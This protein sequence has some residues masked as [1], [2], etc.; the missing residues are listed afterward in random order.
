MK[1]SYIIIIM[2]TFLLMGKNVQGENVTQTFHFSLSELSCDTILGEDGLTYSIF[3]YPTTDNDCDNPGS[4]S[5]PVKYITFPLPYTADD[6]SLSTQCSNV[7]TY[8]IGNKIFPIQEQRA[9]TIEE[10]DYKFIPCESSIYESIMPY[11][12]AQARI[13]EK[14]CVGHGDRHVVV[15]VYPVTYYP[16]NNRYDFAENIEL[17]LSYNHSPQRA[18]ALARGTRTA[19][20]GIPFYEYC[21]ITSRELKP[22]FTR[23]VAWKREKGL[24]AGVVCKEDILNNTHIVGDT[25]SNIYDDAGKIRQ[26]LQYAYDSGTTKYVLFGGNYQVLPI[27]YGTGYND[28]WGTYN[29]NKI[30]SD[31]YFSELNS[32]WNTD[33]DQ[34][35]GEKN[36]S[37]DYGSELY[38]GRLLCKNSEEIHNY[39][40]KLLR[41]ELNPGNGDFSYLKKAL[42]AQSD[43]M[44]NIHEQDDS[45]AAQLHCIFPIDTIFSEKPSYDDPDPT[46]PTGNDVM[47]EMNQHY[48]YVSWGGHGGPYTVTVK[49]R[50]K[51]EPPRYAITSV[52]ADTTYITYIMQESENGL[53]NLT[54]KDYP[55]VA[56]SI[57]CS[58][59]PFDI[60]K[61]YSVLP[62]MGQSFTLG[63]DYGGPLLVG[64]T[65]EGKV[66][67][68]VRMQKFFSIYMIN[69]PLVGAAQN[70]AKLNQE[71]GKSKH[72]LC[73]SSNIIGCPNIRIWTDIPTL[74]S[75]GLS[76][77]ANNYVLS[78]NNSITAAEIG[79]RDI[80]QT[81]EITDTLSFNPSQGA[82]TLANAENC[83]ITLTGKNCLPQIMPLTIQNDTLQG[84]HYAIVKDVACGKDVR[85]PNQGNVI[86][87]E[88][89]NY[90]FET[91]GTFKLTKGVKIKQGA[92]LKVI[93]SEINY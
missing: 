41:Y 22:A 33:G 82:K 46:S 49:S 45:I 68:S 27:R 93:P 12:S 89:S 90:T 73:H 63:K 61:N 15:A 38:V 51:H 85:T 2:C 30:P 66:G 50:N 7:T 9:T 13:V 11:P 84:T 80:T 5:L 14:S 3:A 10:I 19:D 18:Q 28:D 88:G 75:A 8:F 16:A 76:Y 78:A 43:Q 70:F 71:W 53:D 29:I 40:D 44:Q 65:R 55:M 48:G 37:L 59:T 34:Y 35:Y 4:P 77:N 31:L 56:Y 21:V 1:N 92:Q 91:K 69:N 83:L 42:Y 25:I 62:N 72:Y 39:T 52:Q 6:I 20:I 74:F 60:Y 79:I 67:S 86:F 36:D 24:N 54:N 87:D 32:N 58:I 64:N 57:S 26:Y 81:E 23:L 17:T 47:A